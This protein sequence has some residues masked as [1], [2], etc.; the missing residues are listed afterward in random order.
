MESSAARPV[1]GSDEEREAIWRQAARRLSSQQGGQRCQGM[2][3][4]RAK[5]GSAPFL[6]PR[7]SQVLMKCEIGPLTLVPTGAIGILVPTGGYR[8]PGA[9]AI[10]ERR[11]LCR[12]TTRFSKNHIHATLCKQDWNL[13]TS[14]RVK[15]LY[16]AT[17]SPGGARQRRWAEPLPADPCLT[18]NRSLSDPAEGSLSPAQCNP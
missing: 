15:C 2:C 13:C 8:Y 9:T 10:H 7:G 4:A 1:D 16:G 12:R 11:V 3:L 5:D 17:N 14:G 18:R 6:L